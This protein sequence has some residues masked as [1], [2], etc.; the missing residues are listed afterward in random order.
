M[1]PLVLVSD[2]WHPDDV[3]PRIVVPF[4]NDRSDPLV[5]KAMRLNLEMQGLRPQYE[6]LDGTL[7]AEYAYDRLFRR[8]WAEGQPFVIVEH[9][10]LPWPGAVQAIWTCDRPWCGYQYLIFGQM[11][12]QL[13]CVKFDPAR[14]GDCPL[15][16][17]PMAWHSLDWAVIQSMASR[18]ESGHLH[19]PAV[20]HLNWSHQRM[21]ASMVVRPE[22]LP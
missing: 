9:D 4:T 14:L 17:I 16:D 20:S 15:P 21:T 3:Q 8:L 5:H 7:D 13:G 19:E 12:V 22:A 18:G 11:R 2:R 6:R 1:E 10:I